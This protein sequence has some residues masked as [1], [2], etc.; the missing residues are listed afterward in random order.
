MNLAKELYPVFYG[1]ECNYDPIV[2]HFGKVI[3]RSDD[4]DYQGDTRVL[5]QFGEEYGYL[6]FGWG[7]CSGCD[8][9]QACCNYEELNILI[10]DLRNNIKRFPNKES[11]LKHFKEYDWEGNCP[12]SYY[13][14]TKEWI[15]KCI[16]ILSA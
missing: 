12:C 14:E 7:S 5:Y 15:A 3:L 1:M 9:L 13:G 4:E 10:E 11:A 16:E 8:A 6:I 2:N